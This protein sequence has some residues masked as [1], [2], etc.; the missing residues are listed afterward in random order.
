MSPNAIDSIWQVPVYLPYLQSPLETEIVRRAEEQLGVTLPSSYLDLLSEQNGGAVRRTLTGTDHSMIWGIGPYYPSLTGDPYQSGLP[1][2]RWK[3][4]G[5]RRI[6]RAWS[7]STAMDAGSSV[8]TIARAGRR[9]TR[10]GP[11]RSRARA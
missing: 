4:S 8:S 5:C 7:P 11:C 9:P 1:P 2:R 6:H 10:R 3:A